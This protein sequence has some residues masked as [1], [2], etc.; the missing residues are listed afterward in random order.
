MEFTSG[1]H[2]TNY[3]KTHGFSC[4]KRLF[5]WPFSIAMLVYERVSWDTLTG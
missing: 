4:V 2:T 3:G 5:L 1:K